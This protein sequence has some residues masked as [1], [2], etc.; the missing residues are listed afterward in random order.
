MS[1]PRAAMERLDAR[2]DLGAVHL[3]VSDLDRALD[4]YEGRLGFRLHGREGDVARLG[5]GGEDL[6]VLTGRAGAPRAQR[7]T[8]LYHFAVLVPSRADLARVL[9]HLV[10]TET[11]LTGGADHLVSEALYLS[12]PEGNGIEV[13]RDRPRDQ[14]P[15]EGSQPLMATDPLDLH[16]LLAEAE[17]EEAPWEG[18][19]RDTRIGHVHLH[20]SRLD[21][22]ERFYLGVLGFDLVM[23]Y[24]P[25]ALFVS[26]GG[27]HHHVGLNTWAGVGAPR[28]PAGAV[29]L[30]HFVV[31]VR[32]AAELERVRGRV[33]AAGLVDA[34]VPGG[35]AVSD[36]SGNI[37]HFVPRDEGASS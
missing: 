23:R 24:G 35:F 5:A 37:L 9:R 18:L 17:A 16:A 21:E 20:V 32:D 1:D 10:M 12:D 14:W 8:G 11:P 3:T 19:P 30:R 13:Y 7:V 4:F 15:R 6:L 2:T 29:G 31:Q 36:P 34:T 22:A 26:A 33:R 25:S 28:P 27:Y